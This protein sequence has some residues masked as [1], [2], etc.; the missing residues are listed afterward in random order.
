ML[1]LIPQGAHKEALLGDQFQLAIQA[2]AERSRFTPRD[3][4][5]MP[6]DFLGR[7]KAG[8]SIDEEL[9]DL[10]RDSVKNV[11]FL[12]DDKVVRAGSRP[13]QM[14]AG[15]IRT[16]CKLAGLSKR[17]IVTCRIRC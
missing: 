4:I 5:Y 9:R 16:N 15:V 13:K 14:Q 2:F 10:L 1:Q 12:H 7:Q 11:G 8:F 3:I 6:Y 17:P